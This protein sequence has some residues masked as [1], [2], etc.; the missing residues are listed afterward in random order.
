MQGKNFYINRRNFLKGTTAAM[1]LSSFGAYGL[2][3]IYREN[4]AGPD[5]T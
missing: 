4:T 2:D 3:L 5:E 1:A